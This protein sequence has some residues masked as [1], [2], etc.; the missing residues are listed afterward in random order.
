MEN[1]LNRLLTDSEIVLPDG[2]SFGSYDAG[3]KKGKKDT[4]LILA[5]APCRCA[6]V[7]TR[8]SVK[9]HC[10]L[11]NSLLISDESALFRGIAANSGNA[12]ACTGDEGSANNVRFSS[13]VA[14]SFAVSPHEILTASTGV[15][16][17]Q[18]PIES[19]EA[20]SAT[21][22]SCLGRDKD[23]FLAAAEA[24]MTTDTR[25]KC[26]SYRYRYKD[27]TITVAGMAKGSGMIH[28]DMG[29][30]LGFIVTD[31][32]LPQAALQSSL[33]LVADD[34]FNMIS[35]DGDTSTNDMLLLLAPGK[36]HGHLTAES[37]QPE[38]IAAF[39]SALNEVCRHLA[40]EIARDG[41]GASKLLR[42]RVEGAS[43][44]QNAR[45]LA[46][47]VICSSLVKCAFFGEDANWGRILAAMGYSGAD[48]DPEG[49]SIA[50][51]S[52]DQSE[53]ITL[54]E[55]G[56]PLR[57]DEA[58]ASAILSRDEIE[59]FIAMTGGIAAATAWG[60]DLTYDYV[61]INGD[62]RT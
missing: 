23:H 22:V 39:R 5:D 57:F 40:I 56:V 42:C 59:I 31:A 24:I 33:K 29:T 48:F 6:G 35:V 51:R 54:M 1:I 41:E 37:G 38:Y 2:F 26:A 45:T 17:V 9:A 21:A 13:A 61:K 27:E 50:F 49:V 4:A 46:R 3:I 43:S 55:K 10:V 52:F 34:T 30:M 16:G 7:F 20:Q 18:L 32:V 25:R 15:I 60:C 14:G 12:N 28:P 11:R 58:R 44:L 36:K 19:V 8:N 62:Y 47:Q 53:S